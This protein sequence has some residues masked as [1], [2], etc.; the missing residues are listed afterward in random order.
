MASGTIS[1]ETED[2]YGSFLE[3]TWRGERPLTLPDGTERKFLQD[4]DSVVL[5]GVAVKEGLRVGFS[6]V[7]GTISPA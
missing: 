1:G 4:G 5:S 7:K 2:S 6:E 3:L